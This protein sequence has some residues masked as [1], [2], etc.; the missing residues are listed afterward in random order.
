MTYLLCACCGGPA[1]LPESVAFNWSLLFSGA[2]ALA[3]VAGVVT[4]VWGLSSW[5]KQRLGEEK[6]AAARAMYVA[7][8]KVDAAARSMLD[9]A[10]D[11]FKQ[12]VTR[13]GGAEKATLDHALVKYVQG[14]GTRMV[15]SMGPLH[16]SAI[17][18]A[19]FD[20]EF[21]LDAFN[22]KLEALAFRLGGIT[23]FHGV[24]AVWAGAEK[25][26]QEER[27]RWLLD[28]AKAIAGE[29]EAPYDLEG[30]VRAIRDFIHEHM[31]RLRS[32]LQP[33]AK[34]RWWRRRLR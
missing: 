11:R 23:S 5:R 7:L 16:S 18:I 21:D 31:T 1:A 6:I 17:A 30:E 13:I 25:E 24:A 26:G 34:I 8:L 27:Y 10:P 33:N 2:T 32:D 3:A 19:V 29:G 12:L 4:A 20:S 14:Y 28:Q 22:E 15:D 9:L